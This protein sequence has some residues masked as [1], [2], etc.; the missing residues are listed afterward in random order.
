LCECGQRHWRRDKEPNVSHRCHQPPDVDGLVAKQVYEF[1]FIMQPLK[2]LG[3]TGS[4][5]APVAVRLGPTTRKTTLRAVSAAFR[6]RRLCCTAVLAVL[7]N[8]RFRA[9]RPLAARHR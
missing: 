5:V 4:T 2:I 9:G 8:R 1:A 3:G 7:A 6:A